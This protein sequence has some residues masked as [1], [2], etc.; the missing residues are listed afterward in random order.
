MRLLARGPAASRRETSDALKVIA[1]ERA[2][3]I[4]SLQ[5]LDAEVFHTLPLLYSHPAQPHPLVWR[6][7]REVTTE[8]TARLCAYLCSWHATSRPIRYLLSPKPNASP[9]MLPCGCGP[10]LV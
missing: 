5:N 9:W 3:L 4:E 10:T 1:S 6:T 2:A 7:P 8:S